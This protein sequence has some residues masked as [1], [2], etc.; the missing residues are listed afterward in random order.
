MKAK[1][2]PSGYYYRK[3]DQ[4][5]PDKTYPTRGAVS[6]RLRFR[7]FGLHARVLPLYQQAG[8]PF[9]ESNAGLLLW[10]EFGR[11]SRSN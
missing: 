3:Q 8:S 1:K 9:G 10:L 2:R 7:L 4:P 6:L 5:E 11:G